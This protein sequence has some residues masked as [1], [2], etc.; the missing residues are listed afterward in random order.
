MKA[1]ALTLILLAPT[2]DPQTVGGAA[3]EDPDLARSVRRIG[4]ELAQ[5]RGE[6]FDRPPRAVRSPAVLTDIAVEARAYRTVGPSRLEARGRAWN[7]VGLGGP[8]SPQL[9]WLALARDLPGIDLDVDGARLLVSPTRLTDDDYGVTSDERLYVPDGEGTVHELRP[10]GAG[11]DVADDA[12]DFLL[13]TGVRPDEPLL[14]HYLMHLRQLER[15]GEDSIRETTDGLLAAAA[16]SEGEANLVSLYFLFKG[17]GLARTVLTGPVGPADFLDGQLIPDVVEESSPMDASLLRFVYEDGYDFAIERFRAQGW[18]VFLG[19]GPSSTADLLNPDPSRAAVRW[20]DP[21]PPGEGLVAVDT[22]SLG[23]QATLSLISI[24]T[25]RSQDGLNAARNWVGDRLIR[26]ER[27]PD[28]GVT[29]WETRWRTEA[30]AT[31]F[32]AA[33]EKVVRRRDPRTVEEEGA[34]SSKFRRFRIDR[35]GA[36]VRIEVRAVGGSGG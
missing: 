23:A 28:D 4:E 11:T 15:H 20:P 6:G 9:L 34:L 17:V 35:D 32:A 31:G 10:E 3:I 27:A 19:P 30:A 24:W 36:S 2:A 5:A 21:T 7:D 22:D 13:A 33:F 1:L 26:W 8:V 16:W 25:G 12:G 14:A 29:V 18:N